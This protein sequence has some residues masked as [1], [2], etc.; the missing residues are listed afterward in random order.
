MSKSSPITNRIQKALYMKSALKQ[1]DEL[2]A[3]EEKGN[4]FSASDDY[5]TSVD[6]TPT[7]VLEN[8][9]KKIQD[10]DKKTYTYMDLY[11]DSIASGMSEA[12]ANKA[13]DEAKAYNIK[14]YDTHTPTAAGKTDNTYNVKKFDSEGN[15]IMVDDPTGATEQV[16][17]TKN[18][19]KDVP[20][21][22]ERMSHYEAGKAHRG[23]RKQLNTSTRSL[24]KLGYFE[25]EDFG[26]GKGINPDTMKP[27]KNKK[28]MKRWS[29]VG[30][31]LL[32]GNYEIAGNFHQGKSG[33][34]HKKDYTT[35][36]DDSRINRKHIKKDGKVV[37][38]DE[39]LTMKESSPLKIRKVVEGVFYGLGSAVK[40][41]KKVQKSVSKGVESAVD[42]GKGLKETA[43]K[44]YKQGA[45]IKDVP[46]F[47]V[48][49][50]KLV[51]RGDYTKMK[52]KV[53]GI[54]YGEAGSSAGHVKAR[55]A[56]AQAQLDAFNK[57]HKIKSPTG[58][59]SKGGAI[60]GT[61]GVKGHLGKHWGKYTTGAV[62]AGV[63]A[64]GLK[65]DAPDTKPDE[66]DV[67]P[68]ETEV[69]PTPPPVVPDT[70]KTDVTPIETPK[71]IVDSKV[72]GDSEG[73]LVDVDPNTSKLN[74]GISTKGPGDKLSRS[75]R[76]FNERQ[77]KKK[78]RV[79]GRQERKDI[80][81][82]GKARRKANRLAAKNVGGHTATF[83]GKTHDSSINNMGL[84]NYN[85]K[86]KKNK[87]QFGK[88]SRPGYSV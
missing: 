88:T 58:G 83:G 28:E 75:M 74:P 13:V 59:T 33:S 15:P 3:K 41:S 32:K 72:T 49:K 63:T 11:N 65:D 18:V 79:E 64:Y 38:Q 60:T 37:E 14:Q 17:V 43:K 70:E 20:S 44:S 73:T 2:D 53:K 86:D 25:N 26:A 8:R 84:A 31:Q 54:D 29:P 69:T 46:E 48:D 16:E 7:T 47:K 61:G 71:P 57:K 1:A 76:K 39:A 77:E 24:K 22:Y 82:A 66:T 87:G 67:T 62:A 30:Q 42:Y 56:Q 21:S 81:Q 36:N 51:S 45:G 80:R 35:R 10:V 78:K 34:T 19:S 50:S 6:V 85:Q 40:G 4:T 23:R 55:K 27:F 5:G 9:V 52:G 68:S 12:D